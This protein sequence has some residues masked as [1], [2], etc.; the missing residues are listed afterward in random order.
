[1]TF[2]RDSIVIII[3][4]VCCDVVNNYISSAVVGILRSH[5]GRTFTVGVSDA[6][7]RESAPDVSRFTALTLSIQFL[8]V[9]FLKNST[10]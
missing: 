1:L 9:F 10:T 3:L 6:P 8:F 7:R 4:L 5:E 2:F